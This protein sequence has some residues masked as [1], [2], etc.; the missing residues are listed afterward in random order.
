MVFVFRG[1]KANSIFVAVAL[2]VR[3]LC[4]FTVIPKEDVSI[5]GPPPHVEQQLQQQQRPSPLLPTPLYIESAPANSHHVIPP[6][7]QIQPIQP[8]PSLGPRPVTMQPNHA[9]VVD[10]NNTPI[11]NLTQTPEHSNSPIQVIE[12]IE[13]TKGQR[14]PP[15]FPPTNT[16]YPPPTEKVLPITTTANTSVVPNIPPGELDAHRPL[17]HGP[18][19]KEGHAPIRPTFPPA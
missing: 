11:I 13:S 5:H 3:L 4:V 14:P 2:I 19:S 7:Q 16:A 6:V 8:I 17:P 18:H 9:P 12:T 15:T 1:N 10:H